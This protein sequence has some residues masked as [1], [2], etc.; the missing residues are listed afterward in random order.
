MG[1]GA[2]SEL[3]TTYNEIEVTKVLGEYFSYYVNI[4]KI[5]T[6]TSQ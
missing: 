2:P 3:P 6:L 5:Q 4:I 1:N